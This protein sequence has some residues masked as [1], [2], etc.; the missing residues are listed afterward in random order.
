[1]LEKLTDS[2]P[3][4][5]HRLRSL[6]ESVGTVLKVSDFMSTSDNLPNVNI[7]ELH[8][9]F[10]QAIY[11]GSVRCENS[12]EMPF[13]FFCLTIDDN[14]DQVIGVISIPDN[15]SAKVRLAPAL[16]ACQL[17]YVAS[18][19]YDFINCPDYKPEDD[20]MNMRAEAY[21]SEAMKTIEEK[22][23]GGKKIGSFTREQQLARDRF[24]NGVAD[25]GYIQEISICPIHAWAEGYYCVEEDLDSYHIPPPLKRVF[26]ELVLTRSKYPWNIL[27]VEYKDL[28]KESVEVVY[29]YKLTDSEINLI[30]LLLIRTVDDWK[31]S[32]SQSN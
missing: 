3:G 25:L 13:P 4:G 8:S 29:R 19:V 6:Q 28:E 18:Q 5:E 26:H 20:R 12:N 11:S 2:I 14:T 21:E 30:T 23:N 27:E 24:P 32:C 17:T 31:K 9:H 16:C 7:N 10:K 15:Y 1:M 22:E